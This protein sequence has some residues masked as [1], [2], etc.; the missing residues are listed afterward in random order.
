MESAHPSAQPARS[1]VVFLESCPPLLAV[2][3]AKYPELSL[4]A[5]L[6]LDRGEAV[7][8]QPPGGLPRSGIGFSPQNL[9]LE[10]QGGSTVPPPCVLSQSFELQCPS[11]RRSSIQ[12]LDFPRFSWHLW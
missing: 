2:V 5:Q 1:W 9:A 3:R 6:L 10:V 7:C 8:L 11:M 4:V 12:E